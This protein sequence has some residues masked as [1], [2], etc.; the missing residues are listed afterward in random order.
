MTLTPMLRR[1][2]ELARAAKVA[3]EKVIQAERLARIQAAVSPPLGNGELALALEL[4]VT[5]VGRFKSTEPRS[6]SALPDRFTRTLIEAVCSGDAWLAIRGAR[7]PGERREVVICTE[8]EARRLGAGYQLVNVA[9]RGEVRQPAAVWERDDLWDL[10]EE[11]R[12]SAPAPTHL[13]PWRPVGPAADALWLSPLGLGAMRLSTEGRPD[14]ATAIQVLHAAF[15]AGMWIDTAD[16]YARDESEIGHNERLIRQAL[17]TWSGDRDGVVVATKGG[18]VRRGTRWLPDGRPEHLKAA[19]EA[20]LRALGVER[21]DLYQLHVVDNRVPF[22]ES[23]DALAELRA[24]GLIRHVGLCNV[25]AEQIGVALGRVPLASVQNPLSALDT[26]NLSKTLDFCRNANLGF[27]AHSP[28]GGFRKVEHLRA[29]PTFQAV[30]ERHHTTPLSVALA[31][32]LQTGPHVLAVPGATRVETVEAIVQAQRLALTADD[33]ATLA[34]PEGPRSPLADV[35][36]VAVIL[37]TPGAGKSSRIKPFLDRG[38]VRLNRDERGGTLADL[39]PHFTAAAEAGARR[40]VLD[41]TYPTRTSRRGLLEAAA[42]FGLPVRAIHLDT[43]PEA[44]AFHAARRFIERHGRLLSP[45]E[46]KADDAANSFPPAVIFR[47]AKDFEAPQLEEGFAAV[48]RVPYRR[49]LGPQYQHKALILDYDGTLR[50]TH[51]GAIFPSDPADVYVLP[52][53]AEVLARYQ[54]AG[55]KLLGASNQAGVALGQVSEEAVVACLARTNELLGL[56]IDALHCPHP[57]TRPPSCYC[58][59]P[60]PGMGVM[61]IERHQLDPAQCLMVGDR[62]TDQQFAEA[63]GFAFAWADDFFKEGTK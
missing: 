60:L 42:P 56:E 16:V 52:G 36:D 3:E 13:L 18:L 24:R 11:S 51:S 41:N 47:Y 46:I 6:R 21:I 61:L 10:F 32:V 57:A 29:A 58:R 40:F 34:Q 45:D 33:F 63:A 53:R 38:Y 48:R 4:P 50:L 37:G 39:L 14:E 7:R 54:K 1:A 26:A 22:E 8:A 62:D 5:A 23:L 12:P 28:L 35:G 17:A 43:P 49:W 44:A 2:I 15:E 25:S 19:C 20:S 59:K 55:Y 27:I 31:W 30:A 9:G